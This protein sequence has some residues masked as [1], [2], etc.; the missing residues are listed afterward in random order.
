MSLAGAAAPALLLFLGTLALPDTPNS[1]LERGR[2]DEAHRVLARVRARPLGD[3]PGQQ[4]LHHYPRRCM[5]VAFDVNGMGTCCESNAA[6]N[7]P[8]LRICQPIASGGPAQ[9]QGVCVRLTGAPVQRLCS[10][11]RWCLRD[12]DGA[13]CAQVR[14]TR[15]VGLEFQDIKLASQARARS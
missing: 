8:P 2:E 5:P 14:G 6:A 11:R 15:D 12:A 4:A 10:V 9:A 13:V 1:L 3:T 7:F